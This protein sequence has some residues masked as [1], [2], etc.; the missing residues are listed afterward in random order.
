M[1]SQDFTRMVAEERDKLFEKAA[2][3]R[4]E[5]EV[6]Q[7][8]DAYEFA[9][10]AHNGQLRKSGHPYII[11]PIVVA[12][13]VADELKL[14]TNTVMAALLHDVVED[15][16][17]SVEDI[18]E[19]FGDDVAF[20]VR[21]VTKQKKTVY[22]MSKQLDNFKQ[23]LDSINYDIRALLIKL[24][25]RLHNMR[26]LASMRPD[27][28][29]KIAG[30]T[31]YFYAPLANRLG[32]YRI[33]NELENLSLR[34]RTPVEYAELERQIHLFEE[35][36]EDITE[37]FM[38]PLRDRLLR[39]GIRAKV[40]C[41]NRGVCAI[42]R[43]IQLTGLSFRQVEPLQIVHIVFEYDPNRGLSEKNQCLEIYSVLTDL[44]KEKPGSLVNYIDSP[45]EN[46]YQAIHSKVMC[47][48]GRWMEVHIASERMDYNSALG[49]IAAGEGV[50]HWVE[51][52][53][54]VLKDIAECSK[55][56]GFIENIVC[57]FYN[58]DITVFTPKGHAVVL[59]KGA[60]AVDMAYEIHTD[61]GNRARYAKINGQLA[62]L[63][64]VLKRGDRVEIGMEVSACPQ[65]EWLDSVKTY[66]ARKAIL[67]YLRKMETDTRK[68]PYKL[69]PLCRPLPGDEVSGFE[70]QDGTI[71][72]HKRNCHEAISLSARA[73]DSIVS[74]SLSPDERKNFPVSV[75]V[76]GIDRDKMLYDLVKVI[77]IDLNLSIDSLAITVKDAIATCLFGFEVHSVHE[78]ATAIDCLESVAGVEEVKRKN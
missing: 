72:V 30:E 19:R 48:S 58:D 45:K 16:G 11:H 68:P 66:K 40:W 14:E 76:I 8:R 43:K 6:Q 25:D 47:G 1:E 41:K 42:W 52:F 64:T 20:L 26:T 18:G 59:P 7:I 53:K 4:S 24:A 44:Y 31:D 78:L 32:L 57:N 22:E 28:Q 75:S 60:T 37:R 69:C 39:A 2:V 50:E 15:T 29:M 62:S 12:T 36:N 46:G 74:V 23:M 9:Y 71:T 56:D 10:I 65:G 34:F 77:S 73:G 13:I 49:C 33:K 5:A 61:I 63:R 54:A 55:E 35:E 51:T 27:K 21:V 3:G 67:A 38:R 17:Y 70:N